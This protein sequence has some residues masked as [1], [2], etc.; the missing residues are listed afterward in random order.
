MVTCG[1]L[2]L[3]VVTCGYL[4]KKLLFLDKSVVTWA[5]VYIASIYT[6]YKQNILNNYVV[7]TSNY[8]CLTFCKALICNTTGIYLCDQF[9]R[10]EQYF[11]LCIH[12]NSIQ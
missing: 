12:I 2:R 3:L 1:Y 4:C 7:R 9:A 11:V 10:F 6:P 8:I 5:L